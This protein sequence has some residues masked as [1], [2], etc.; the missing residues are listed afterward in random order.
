LRAK[1]SGVTISID[2][3]ITLETGKKA[4]EAGANQ[5]VVG[6]GIFKSDNVSKT[7]SD[8]NSI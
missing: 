8:F 6:S 4:I 7:L 2:G 5:L 3:G 1:Y